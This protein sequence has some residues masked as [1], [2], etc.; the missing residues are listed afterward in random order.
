MKTKT[1][2]GMG[3]VV[4]ALA[5]FLWAGCAAEQQSTRKSSAEAPVEAQGGEQHNNTIAADHNDAIDALFRRKA[6]ILHRCWQEEYERSQNRK[7]E[8]DI[9]IQMMIKSGKAHDIKVATAVSDLKIK[10]AAAERRRQIVTAGQ[11]AVGLICHDV[12]LQRR[13]QRR[14]IVEGRSRLRALVADG[15][16]TRGLYRVA[17]E[18]GD[19]R[20]RRL[21]PIDCDARAAVFRDTALN[22]GTD[23]P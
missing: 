11:R 6:S 13:E 5:G 23:V 3:M 17:L 19:R 15:S 22:G 16:I 7:L 18:Q 10:R 9:T 12:N 8:G 14:T 1:M 4:V 2:G 21:A 20:L